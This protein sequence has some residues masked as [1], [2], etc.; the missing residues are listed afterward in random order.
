MLKEFKEN[1]D[2]LLKIVG[3]A[4][5]CSIL[6][7]MQNSYGGTTSEIAFFVCYMLVIILIVSCFTNISS[8][9]IAT[10]KKLSG[11]MNV[12]IPVIMTLAVTTGNV[13]TVFTLQ[14]VMLA[15]VSVISGVVSNFIIPIITISTIIN[16]VANISN[17]ISVEKL[18]KFF[19]KYSMH[20]L[21]IMMI[22]FAGVLSIEG[23]LASTVDGVTGKVAKTVV[24]NGVPV[25]GKLISDAT[26]SVIG[27]VSVTKN[28]VGTIGI[29]IIALIVI[30][31]V[32]KSFVLMTLFNLTSAISDAIA[33]SRISKCM[34]QT[35]DSIKL[36]FGIMI[37]VSGLFIIAITILIK[38]SNFSL[39]YR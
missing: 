36:I 16:L 33:D 1:I 22:I 20:L 13:A 29:L 39:M 12:T 4:F 5:V 27:A 2:I 32:I 24:A 35:A 6:K 18:S 3:I 37:M 26:E 19:K 7:N 25:I 8:I 34:E 23:S 9:C 15:M 17:Q 10:I 38:M 11:F 30:S 31:P 14:S 21:E 28:A